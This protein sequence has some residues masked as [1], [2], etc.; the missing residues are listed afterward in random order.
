MPLQDLR[1]KEACLTLD[2]RILL[3]REMRLEVS[4][5]KIGGHISITP[6]KQEPPYI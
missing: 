2:A 5:R 1:R 4:Y 3:D 6:S